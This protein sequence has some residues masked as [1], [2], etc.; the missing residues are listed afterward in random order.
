M[1]AGDTTMSGSK[2]RCSALMLCCV[3]GCASDGPSG[4]EE[5]ESS[6]TSTTTGTAQSSSS[7]DGGDPRASSD[8]SSTSTDSSAGSTGTSE[9]EPIGELFERG[10]RDFDQSTAEPPTCTAVCRR[11]GGFCEDSAAGRSYYQ[12][13]T[14]SHGGNFY[15]CDYAEDPEY[16]NGDG[17][18]CRLSEYSCRCH[19]VEVENPRVEVSR[20]E[21]GL[22]TC[23]EVCDSWRLECAW[24][25]EALGPDD[26]H[27]QSLECEDLPLEEAE[28]YDCYCGAS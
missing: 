14:G 15:T 2:M 26:E 19:D 11:L 18:L 6:T 8:S 17:E 23:T 22:H 25:G 3:I 28:S 12:C 7:G 21:D 5:P 13:E 10:T 9:R 1:K 24:G 20:T 27:L 16:T 4:R